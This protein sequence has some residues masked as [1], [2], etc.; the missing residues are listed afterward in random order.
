MPGADS[1]E[2]ILA[3]MRLGEL[4]YLTIRISPIT[5]AVVA[6]VMANQSNRSFIKGRLITYG[7]RVC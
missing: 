4:G 7:G 1:C 5:G 6:P 2:L 3:P